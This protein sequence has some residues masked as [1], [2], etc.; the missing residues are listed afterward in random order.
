MKSVETDPY[1]LYRKDESSDLQGPVCLQVDD[2]IGAGTA[3]FLLEEAKASRRFKTRSAEILEDGK[4]IKFNGHF[5]KREEGTIIVHQ[6]SYE[7]RITVEKHDRTPESFMSNFVK[8]SYL[9]SCMQPDVACAVNQPSRRKAS[10]ATEDDF[11]RL[12]I[13]LKR[14]REQRVEVLYGYV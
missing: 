14:L 8:A 3:G 11:K 10:G 9:I 2:S 6:H 7:D 12:E 13:A 1:F 5:I 4:E